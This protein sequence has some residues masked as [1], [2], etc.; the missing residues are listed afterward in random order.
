MWTRCDPARS[1]FSSQRRL[2]PLRAAGFTPRQ[3][4]VHARAAHGKCGAD[5]A[6]TIAEPKPGT[7]VRGARG[8][9]QLFLSAI[10][11]ARL[12]TVTVLQIQHNDMNSSHFTVWPSPFISP[13]H[14][15]PRD[16]SGFRSSAR[17]N[18]VRW[19]TRDAPPDRVSGAAAR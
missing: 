19:D 6:P 14:S 2:W 18:R 17:P 9:T 3:R 10:A 7:G 12:C 4:E 16:A 13:C 5:M 8:E 11:H 1:P 15:N